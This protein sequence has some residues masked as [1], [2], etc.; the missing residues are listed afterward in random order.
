M[1]FN[2]VLEW[3]GSSAIGTAFAQSTWL[4]PAAETVHVITITLVVGTV[5]VAD[6]RLL[7]WTDRDHKLDVILRDTLP[8]T[9]GAY[10]LAVVSG[11]LM[12]SSGPAKYVGNIYFIVKMILMVAA[13]INMVVFHRFTQSRAKSH[14]GTAR[15]GRDAA[16][17]AGGISIALWIGVVLAG[18][19]IG[20]TAGT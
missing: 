16:Y 7:N 17:L 18:R 14:E 2:D 13:G 3:I 9:W 19:W 6:L 12:F 15:A 4:F 5:M 10:A 11:L 8:W 1:S 20:F